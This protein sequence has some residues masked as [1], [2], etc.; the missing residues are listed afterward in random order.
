MTSVT[1]A[2]VQACSLAAAGRTAQAEAL[3]LCQSGLGTAGHG[4]DF[5]RLKSL[6]VLAMVSLEAFWTLL[7]NGSQSQRERSSLLGRH[8]V[9]LKS[10]TSSQDDLCLSKPVGGSLTFRPITKFCKTHKVASLY[11][12]LLWTE[13]HFRFPEYSLMLCWG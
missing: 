7:H 1:S 13:Y 12:N 2:G 9:L 11:W 5:L 8:H 10:H 3:E 4:I 6:F